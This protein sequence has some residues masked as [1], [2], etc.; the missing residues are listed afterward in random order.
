MKKLPKMRVLFSAISLVMLNLLLTPSL[1]AQTLISGVVNQYARIMSLDTCDM[2]ISVTDA[3]GFSRGMEVLIYQANGCAI[4]DRN[5]AEFGTLQDLRSVGFYEFNRIDSISGT[6]IFLNRRLINT[7]N[8][9]DAAVQLI[10]V[11]NYQEAIVTDTL[12]PRAWNGLLG[13]V[14]VFRATTLTLRAPIDAS[15]LGFRGGRAP[16][17]FTTC[18]GGSSAFGYAYPAS[19]EDGAPKG[20]GLASYIAGKENG[21]G[22]QLTGGGGG[23]N[24]NAGGGGGANLGGGG[25]G[26]I[27]DEPRT[28]GCKGDAP[29][30]GGRAMTVTNDRLYMGGGGGAGHDNNLRASSGGNGGGIIIIKANL[31][32]GDAPT[33]AIRSNGQNAATAFGDGAGGGGAGGTILLEIDN[34]NNPFTIQAKGG[35][36]G[37]S[38]NE[39]ANRCMGTGGGGAGGRIML[40]G[41]SSLGTNIDAGVAGQVVNSSAC[42]GTTNGATA[43]QAGAIHTYSANTVLL[44]MGAREVNRTLAISAQ[45]LPTRVCMSRNTTISVNAT[46]V[47]LTYQWQMDNGTGFQNLTNGGNFNNVNSSTLNLS[48]VSETLQGARFRCIVTSTC[49]QPNQS[50]T[51]ADAALS[52]VVLPIP[53]FRADTTDGSNVVRFVNTSLNAVRVRWQFAD[54]NTSTIS[55]PTHRYALQGTYNV[56]LT[57]YNE[58]DSISITIPVPVNSRPKANFSA[59]A[60]NNCVPA[61]VQ[62]TKIV[63]DNTLSW[64][65]EFPGGSPLTSTD[66][67]PVV[68]Y[69]TGG[70]FDVILIAIN[71]SGRDTLRR[72]AYVR[73]GG[74]PNTTFTWVRSGLTISFAANSGGATSLN[75][76]FG[77]GQSS[78][79]TNPQ[80]TYRNAGTY[81]VSLTASNGCG[82]TV[83]RDTLVLLNLPSA[84]VTASPRIGCTPMRVQF[85]GQNATNVNNWRW[86]FPGGV[87]SISV[88][89]NPVVTYLQ[90]GTYS[91]SLV[92]SNSAGNQTF[93]LPNFIT[94]VSAPS[95]DFGYRVVGNTVTFQNRSTGATQYNWDFGNGDISNRPD[96][97]FNYVYSRDGN[98]NVTLT[99]QNPYC[100]AATS[101]NV[102]INY[103]QTED[104]TE[105]GISVFPN[106]TQ[107]ALTIVA[108]MPNEIE[109]AQIF[110]LQGELLTEMKLVKTPQQTIDISEFPNGLYILKILNQKN[111]TVRK[112]IKF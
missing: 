11:P 102:P 37:N 31:I 91:A 55:N 98:Y 17:P 72:T 71:A 38:D 9:A 14:L 29:G 54:G 75:W 32:I 10:S 111:T 108:E 6:T 58:C 88:V 47:G 33:A 48:N 96:L 27:N 19:S 83:V 106:P 65:W 87:P 109:K 68:N 8:L 77:D 57:A 28:F 52:V 60:G 22:A 74:A 45:P 80:H 16:N 35:N 110:S 79:Q 15:G 90:P 70:N 44:Y 95:A 51:S 12:K 67:S 78:S 93:D 26:G 100:G 103:T 23:N 89:Q 105:G 36:G 101:R 53:T 50:I 81:V 61:Q 18:P 30:V 41:M 34:M 69:T 94:V 3:T 24:H 59:N 97:E 21:R 13:G 43:G 86:S 99:V 66:S 4:S 64:I 112:I 85:S 5:S 62:F 107:S 40:K 46:G 104:L 56:T 82:L 42:S 39:G 25:G 20:E 2:R 7:Y 76:L 49:Q 84:V 63:S 73:V 92:I 1:T